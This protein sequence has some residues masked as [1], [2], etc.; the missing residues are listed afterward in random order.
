M[1]INMVNMFL[2]HV[3]LRQQKNFLGVLYYSKKE[4]ILN[5]IY[6][7]EYIIQYY[8][9]NYFYCTAI[10]INF[11]YNQNGIVIKCLN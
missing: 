2:Y 4:A 10:N 5:N 1:S 11:I 8:K 7:L 6:E 9:Q 3:P